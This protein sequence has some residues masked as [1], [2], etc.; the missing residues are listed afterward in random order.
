MH[1]IWANDLPDN[2]IGEVVRWASK[3]SAGEIIIGESRHNPDVSRTSSDQPQ[4]SANNRSSCAAP[5]C[6]LEL[7][8]VEFCKVTSL[9]TRSKQPKSPLC[10]LIFKFIPSY[11]PKLSQCVFPNHIRHMSYWRGARK[12]LLFMEK[13]W[14]LIK[15]MTAKVVNSNLLNE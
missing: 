6:G 11:F 15:G 1:R 10:C 9:R 5:S 8:N 7:R 12:I 2:C 13:V 4:H 14:R 3:I